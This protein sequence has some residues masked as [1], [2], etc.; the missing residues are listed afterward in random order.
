MHNNHTSMRRGRG[1]TRTRGSM[2]SKGSSHTTARS[3]DAHSSMTHRPRVVMANRPTAWKGE[4][5]GADVVESAVP[6]AHTAFAAV[7][8]QEAGVRRIV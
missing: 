5:K 1:S 3:A 6:D 2:E 8:A 4:A 7:P